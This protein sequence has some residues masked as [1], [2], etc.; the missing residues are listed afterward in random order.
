MN[1]EFDDADTATPKITEISIIFA[2]WRAT[3]LGPF[4]ITIVALAGER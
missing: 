3:G 4:I 2:I 1:Y